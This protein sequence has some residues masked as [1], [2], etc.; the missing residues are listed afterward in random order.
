MYGAAT[1][2]QVQAHRWLHTGWE[3][4]GGGGGCVLVAVVATSTR[5]SGAVNCVD[6]YVSLS[7]KLFPDRWKTN[8]SHNL[9]HI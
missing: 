8:G 6:L 7:V 2:T 9:M 5:G 4:S 3:D 1:E